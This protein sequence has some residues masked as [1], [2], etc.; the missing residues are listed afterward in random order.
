MTKILQGNCKNSV[1]GQ[2]KPRGKCTSRNVGPMFLK[3]GTPNPV[4]RKL[5][6]IRPNQSAAHCRILRSAYTKDC[7]R[8]RL[9]AFGQDKYKNQ[10][11]RYMQGMSISALS[12]LYKWFTSAEKA[13]YCS[14][15]Y[16]HS[17]RTAS[18]RRLTTASFIRY[19]YILLQYLLLFGIFC[20]FFFCC[21]LQIVF[22]SY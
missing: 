12:I 8:T 11:L 3:Q 6:P 14:P 18:D 16:T 19:V 5:G 4:I 15:H 1:F 20:V 21:C 10:S 22:V 7:V 2:L 9:H 13:G 17:S